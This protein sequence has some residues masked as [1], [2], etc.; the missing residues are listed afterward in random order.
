VDSQPAD[1]A[2]GVLAGAEPSWGLALDRDGQLADRPA[3]PPQHQIGV[4]CVVVTADGDVDFVQQGAQQLLAVFIGGGVRIP[5]LTEVV[6][7]GEDRGAF[8]RRQRFGPG[9]LAAG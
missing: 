2:D 8:L 9:G 4:S 3:F 7:E 6:A 1:Q 5:D